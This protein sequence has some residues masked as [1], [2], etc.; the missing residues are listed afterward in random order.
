[1]KD[2]HAYTFSDCMPISIAEP[3]KSR[4]TIQ[5]GVAFASFLSLNQ[6]P[7]YLTEFKRRSASSRFRGHMFD[8]PIL[9][10]LEYCS[11]SHRWEARATAWPVG[12]LLSLFNSSAIGAQEKTT[13]HF[14]P[15]RATNYFAK[16]HSLLRNPLDHPRYMESD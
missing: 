5:I 13:T 15:S 1:M 12:P 4:R 11:V 9:S 8:L 10:Q 2:N 16:N 7:G 3:E 14:K 6:N